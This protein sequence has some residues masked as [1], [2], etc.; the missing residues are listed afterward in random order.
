MRTGVYH[1]AVGTAMIDAAHAP[2]VKHRAANLSLFACSLATA[3]GR[4]LCVSFSYTMHRIQGTC[5]DALYNSIL[6]T[7]FFGNLHEASVVGKAVSCERDGGRRVDAAC[8][9]F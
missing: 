4:A 6:W 8:H 7:P 3:Q 5:P 1:V 2:V 9:S